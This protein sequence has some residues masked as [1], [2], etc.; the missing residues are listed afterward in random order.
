M[1][2]QN[3]VDSFTILQ[4]FEYWWHRMCLCCQSRRY[5]GAFFPQ[6]LCF[7]NFY[8]SFRH[9]LHV[10]CCFS[11][12]H[13]INLMCGAAFHVHLR[14]G[15]VLLN[16]HTHARTHLHPR[17]VYCHVHFLYTKSLMHG[18]A[19][20]EFEWLMA[21]SVVLLP[22]LQL[23]LV[24]LLLSALSPWNLDSFWTS[25]VQAQVQV[26]ASP[27]SHFLIHPFPLYLLQNSS[28]L[29]GHELNQVYYVAS[30]QSLQYNVQRK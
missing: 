13:Y 15:W 1:F 22:G 26:S 19:A 16:H 25:L 30:Q 8:A 14:C 10:C 12:V 24:S 23:K 29:G 18:V 6:Y 4:L 20:G 11:P 21:A 9:H 5:L 7:C 2:H 27:L 3:Q 28:F 17:A